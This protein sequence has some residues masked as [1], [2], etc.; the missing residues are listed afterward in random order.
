[1][2]AVNDGGIYQVIVKPWDPDQLLHLVRRASE[3]CQLERDN[4]R[5]PMRL[6][7]QNDALHRLNN[8][9]DGL[10]MRRTTNLLDGLISALDLRDTETQWHSRRVS[11]YA[12]RLGQQL[13]LDGNAVLDEYGALLHDVGKIGISDTILLKPGKLTEDEWSVM[14]THPRLGYELLKGIDFLQGAA[15]IVLNHHERFDGSGYPQ[16]LKGDAIALGARIFSV[17]DAL[18]VITTNR[19]YKRAQ[20][21]ERALSEVKR[22]T[23]TQFDPIVAEAFEQITLDEWRS[24]QGSYVGEGEI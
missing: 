20:P 17:V 22:C 6:E 3:R 1:M 24:I 15:Q 14:R 2:S 7:A 9:L 23:G 8:E 18:D 12:K 19:P 11:A 16:G 4:A 13:G 21:F 5:L 10:V